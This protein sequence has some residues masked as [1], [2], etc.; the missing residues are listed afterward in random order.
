MIATIARKEF[1]ELMRDGR[2]RWAAAIL[3]ALLAV[4][5]LA[6]AYYQR[7]LIAQQLAAPPLPPP[8]P[9][10]LSRI[11]STN[12]P[13]SGPRNGLKPRQHRRFSVRRTCSPNT[14]RQ[15]LDHQT[16]SNVVERNGHRPS[17]QCGVAPLAWHQ[18]FLWRAN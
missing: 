17:W 8:R 13:N 10:G 16:L 18:P 14:V 11:R 2:F 3:L 1:V 7:E 6:G 12:M 5:L 15:T 4:A 9:S